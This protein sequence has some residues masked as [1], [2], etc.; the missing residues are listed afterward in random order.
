VKF[1]GDQGKSTCEHIGQFLAQL[2]ELADTEAF[3]VC[4]FSLSLTG[5]AFT[6]YV[7]LPPD[8]IVS[9]ADLEQKFHEHFF[10]G[11]YKLDLVDLVAL[12]Q[13]KDELV[14]EYIRR[15]QDTRNRCFQIQLT[16]KQVAGLAF[17]GLRY[18]LKEILEGIR[19]FTLAQL[20]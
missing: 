19:F 18:Y 12:W 20:H 11:D 1:S 15:L 2:G 5:T 9:W 16:E 3:Y 8:S 14:N 7:M 10:S 6:W 17:N 4:F 13:G